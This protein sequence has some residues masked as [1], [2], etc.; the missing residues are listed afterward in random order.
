[1][2]VTCPH[3]RQI[4]DDAEASTICPHRLLMP[5]EDLDRK[6]LAYKLLGKLVRFNHE[7]DGP[8]RRVDSLNCLGM[9]TLAKMD[10]VPEMVGEFAPHLFVI[11]E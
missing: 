10:G 11:K 6:D 9:V 7:P 3:C 5:R 8:Y 4:F 1:M 2:T